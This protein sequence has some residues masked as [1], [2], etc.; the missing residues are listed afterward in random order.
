MKKA[1]LFL[2]AAVFAISLQAQ[3][4]FGIRGGLSTTQLNEEKI[5]LSN[6]GL[7]TLGL[8][9]KDADYGVH[10]GVFLQGK[11]G[12]FVIQPEVLFNSS[13]V[14]FR[15]DGSGQSFDQVFKE[16][17]QFIDIPVLL[18]A[19]FGPL[20]LNAGPVGHIFVNS[21]S[22]LLQFDQYKQHFETLTLGWQGGI[23][24][25]IWSLLIDLRY[26]GNF[27]KFGDHIQFGGNQYQFSQTPGRFIASV[28]IA[29]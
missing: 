13:S 14:N 25:D 21:S 12:A 23:G 28:G 17:Y 2:S 7:E 24:L 29:F 15:V 20:R 19:K 11:I 26:E 1:I 6:G 18:G 9:I 5:S 27:N 8:A 4:K 16:K 10:L 3:V 22:D